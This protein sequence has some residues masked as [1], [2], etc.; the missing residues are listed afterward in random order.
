MKKRPEYETQL[1]PKPDK[2][3]ISSVKLATVLGHIRPDYPD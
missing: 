2:T 1:Q 3:F